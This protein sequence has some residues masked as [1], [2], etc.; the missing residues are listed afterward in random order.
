MLPLG[1]R[2]DFLAL[3][4]YT[5]TAANNKHPNYYNTL[6]CPLVKIILSIYTLK[7]FCRNVIVNCKSDD[8]EIRRLSEIPDKIRHDKITKLIFLNFRTRKCN[9][10]GIKL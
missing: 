8:V 1:K 10:S 7:K 3:K 5:K 6:H 2:R 9:L 4:Y